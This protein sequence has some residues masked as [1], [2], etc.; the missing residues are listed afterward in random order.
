M[1]DTVAS[2]PFHRR[3]RRYLKRAIRPAWRRLGELIPDVRLRLA[4]LG[5][6]GIFLGAG[7][8]WTACL[9][10]GKTDVL[11][12][13]TADILY[14]DAR[15]QA[16]GNG[17]AAHPFR[18]L[19]EAF[20]RAQA[21]GTTPIR[22][23]LSNGEYRG[24]VLLTDGVT[25]AGAGRGRTVLSGSVRMTG[26][27]TL[28]DLTL[29]AGG[30]SAVEVEQ[31]SDVMLEQVEI[32]NHGKTA[33]KKS[34]DGGRLV[35]LR[36][37]I[38][39]G[40]GKG[41]YVE[42]DNQILVADN[43]IYGN[44]EEALDLRPGIRG[45]IAR[46]AIFENEEAAIEFIIGDAELAIRG[47]YLR[48]N[49][50]NNLAPQFL[51][52]RP[53]PGRIVIEGNF[54]SNHR[55]YA[56]SCKTPSG[57]QVPSN[58]W[59]NSLLLQNNFFKASGNRPEVNPNTCRFAYVNPDTQAARSFDEAT[60]FPFGFTAKRAADERHFWIE[61]EKIAREYDRTH[62]ELEEAERQLSRRSAV[63]LFLIG[64]E[65]RSLA[66]FEDALG[67]QRAL[68]ERLLSLGQPVQPG[69]EETRARFVQELDEEIGGRAAVHAQLSRS[70]SLL[71]WIFNLA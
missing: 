21:I 45:E 24:D 28:R 30:I 66:R 35:I 19:E 37:S 49:G 14:V 7:V 26:A 46:N 59:R 32:R 5:L 41:I 34:P 15:R 29:D 57:G 52:T 47:N 63:K 44:P 67:R 2:T 11:P 69:A 51:D 70:F 53:A 40:K 60:T 36:S 39:D 9:V 12:P 64:A 55:E 1:A 38:H 6:A 22:I 56:V 50:A 18:T 31:G 54:A 33:V 58:Y 61:L 17:S 68:R 62:V 27:S 48:E 42:K 23:E 43:I 20:S 25:L 10:R 71:G 4:V 13:V 3:I 65:R 8:V 16:P